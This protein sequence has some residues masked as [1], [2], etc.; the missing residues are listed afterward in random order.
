[1]TTPTQIE[2]PNCHTLIDVQDVLSHQLEEK[3]KGEFQQKLDSE[4]LL[5][6]Q[7]E[8][9]LEK[10]RRDFDEKQKGVDKLFQEQL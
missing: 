1:M 3:L 8:E 2:C 7:K 9:A 5:L 4:K 6:Q 10:N